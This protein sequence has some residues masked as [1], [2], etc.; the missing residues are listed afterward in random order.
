ME[1]GSINARGHHR[2]L[3]RLKVAVAAVLLIRLLTGAGD[4]QIRLGESTLFGVNAP[5]DGIG[6]LKLRAIQATSQ[7]TTL[8]LPAEGMT[9]KN[10]RN[11]QPLTDEGTHQTG[12]GVMGMN[13]IHPLA[14]LAQMFHQLISQ[15]LEMGPKQLLAQIP[16]RT[17]GEAQDAGPWSN[18]F[19][20]L[21]VIEIDPTVLNQPGDHINLLNLRPLR[22]AAH[23]LQHI[24]R[25]ATGISVPSQ[26]ELMGTKQTVK[27][28]MQQP[29]PHSLHSQTTTGRRFG[30]VVFSLEAEEG[31]KNEKNLRRPANQ[32][33]QES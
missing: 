24:Q 11:P 20:P 19:D 26:F 12:I 9:R 25:L 17:E 21:A 14:G 13:P 33:E 3:I 18:G 7:E 23:E 22:Q 1:P 32:T 5:A 6:L 27:V 2:R 8:F 16:L 31:V 28:Q 10:K 30:A 4:H 29:D 15:L